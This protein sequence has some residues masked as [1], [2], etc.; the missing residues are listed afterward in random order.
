MNLR[1]GSKKMSK[2]DASD[3]SRI[4][5]TDDADTIALKIRKARTDPEPLP[6]SIEGLKG[7]PE[8]ENLVGIFAALAEVSRAEVCARFAGAPFSAFKDELAAL[9]IDKL[10]PITSEMRRLMADP[11][12]V[13][14]VLRDGAE[15]AAALAET[16]PARGP[17]RGRVPAALGKGK[18]PRAATIGPARHRSFAKGPESAGTGGPGV[19]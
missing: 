4:N 10:G 2:S 7:R 13:D 9:A 6:D 15:R 5:L 8:A 19:L 12:H 18:P 3:Y 14:G 11:G 16:H 17:R 1:D